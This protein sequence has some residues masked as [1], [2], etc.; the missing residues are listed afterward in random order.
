MA[1][2]RKASTLGRPLEY[3]D[4]AG[5]FFGYDGRIR[6]VVLSPQQPLRGLVALV[7]RTA[8]AFVAVRSGKFCT[9]REEY[10]RLF[11]EA[12]SGP[13]AELVEHVVRRCRGDWRYEVPTEPGS[14]AELCDMCREVLEF[15]RS[16]LIEFDRA[17]RSRTL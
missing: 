12:A 5:E 14:R 13:S 8:I 10:L 7:A 15:E 16:S 3:P 9:S 1:A 11:R 2:V 4:P 6:S 17:T